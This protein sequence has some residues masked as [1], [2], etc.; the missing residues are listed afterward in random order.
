MENVNLLAQDAMLE[1][2]AI[3]LPRTLA[4]TFVCS[5]PWWPAVT[6]VLPRCCRPSGAAAAVNAASAVDAVPSSA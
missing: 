6:G 3:T 5:T 1:A 4:A 2:A